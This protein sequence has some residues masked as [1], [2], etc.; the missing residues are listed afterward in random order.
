MR[1]RR[2]LT[3]LILF[4]FAA[5]AVNLFST[6]LTVAQEEKEEET[7]PDTPSV[8][9]FLES[10]ANTDKINKEIEELFKKARTLTRNDVEE[11]RKLQ[12]EYAAKLNS[13]KTSLESMRKTAIQ[14]LKDAPQSSTIGEILVQIAIGDIQ[15]DDYK[16]AAELLN[17][18]MMSKN[19]ADG[20]YD[21]AT[22]AAFAQNDFEAAK[23]FLEQSVANKET[24]RVSSRFSVEDM[25]G[26]I[27]AWKKEKAIRDAEAKKNDLPRVQLDTTEGKI[28]IELYENEAPQA[29][30]NFVSLVEKKYYDGL[31]FHRVL[32]G[33]MAQGGCPQGTGT[34]GPGYN[35]YCECHQDN[36]RKHFAGTLSMAHAGKDTG[37]SQ[38]FLTFLPTPHLDGRHTAFGRVVEGMDV[39]SKL[40]RVNPQRPSGEEPSK[41]VKATVIRKRDHDYQPTKVK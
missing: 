13:L 23:K 32:P 14:A 22:M 31:I 8:K 41:I 2:D 26:F 19:G 1:V 7:L 35:I 10:K 25:D 34:G 6:G 24:Q 16:G 38:F 12:T 30:A 15:G 17:V 20:I 4:L 5:T 18:L 3:F 9:A 28:V 11:I 36:Y 29:V 21:A 40:K 33:F 27:A 37:G 39:L